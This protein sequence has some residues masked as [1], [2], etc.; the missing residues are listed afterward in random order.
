M[1]VGSGG[2]V[3]TKDVDDS[4]IAQNPKAFLKQLRYVLF[5]HFADQF[6]P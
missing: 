2:E 4:G 6:R 5:S 1:F 3:E